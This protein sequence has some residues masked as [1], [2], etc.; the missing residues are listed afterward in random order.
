[1]RLSW[2][3]FWKSDFKIA[4]ADLASLFECPVCF[5]YALPP[6]LQCQSGHIVCSACRP[7]L[8]CC[9]TCRG[10]LG[11]IRNLAMEKV[12]STVMF[13]CKYASSGCSVRKQLETRRR[14]NVENALLDRDATWDLFLSSLLISFRW[15]CC[16]TT[17]R[18]TKRRA[19]FDRIPAHVPV[20]LASGKEAS[21][22]SWFIWWLRIRVSP[23]CKVNCIS[24]HCFASYNKYLSFHRTMTEPRQQKNTK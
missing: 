21:S 11:N 10:P 23:R 19:N 18:I 1:M 6:I 13:P 3:I 14:W 12:A 9:P 16:I 24:S 15:R 20:P 5:D 8:Q 17:K 4:I 7:K 2:T 22:K